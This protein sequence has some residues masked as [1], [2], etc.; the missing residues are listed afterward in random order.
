MLAAMNGARAVTFSAFALP[1]GAVLRELLEAARRGAH[2]TVRL[3]GCFDHGGA[4]VMGTQNRSAVRMLR[5]L[6][7]DARLVHTRDSDGPTMHLKAAVCDKVAFLDD[8]NWIAGEDNIVLRD[9]SPRDVAAIR[10]AACGGVPCGAARPA[11]NKYDALRLETAVVSAL[12]GDHIEVATETIASGSLV[13]GA[14]KAAASRH[15]KL[16]IS[17]YGLRGKEGIDARRLSSYGVQVRVSRSCEKFAL[18]GNRGWI[19]SANATTPHLNN[20][21]DWGACTRSRVLVQ[22]LRSRFAAEWKHARP[23]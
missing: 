17:T 3:N 10:T 15:P 12:P 13:Y 11:L 20:S 2:V 4:A 22:T 7:A 14:L 5:R 16:L 8:R 1:P 9:D 18:N 23:L 19:G 6:G 21:T